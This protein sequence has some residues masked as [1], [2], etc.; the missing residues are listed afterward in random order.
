MWLLDLF[1]KEKREERRKKYL[2]QCAETLFDV[3]FSEK[4]LWLCYNGQKIAPMSMLTE[5]TDVNEC[6]A[7][8]SVIRQL[9]VKRNL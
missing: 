9:Y 5:K 1:D 6:A 4:Q 3:T 2:E 8:V 7:L